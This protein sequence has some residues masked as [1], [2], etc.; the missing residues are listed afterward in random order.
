MN[1]IVAHVLD[2]FDAQD[3]NNARAVELALKIADRTARSDL[4][5]SLLGELEPGSINHWWWKPPQLDAEGNPP[6]HMA[7]VAPLVEYLDL[8]GLIV[9]KPDAPHWIHFVTRID[10]PEATT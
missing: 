2:R 10:L 1:N 3:T 7:W 6:Y 8:R 5:C 4:E 9:R